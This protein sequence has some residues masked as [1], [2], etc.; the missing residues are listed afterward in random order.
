M[1][2]RCSTNKKTRYVDKPP[3]FEEVE[4]FGITV[5]KVYDCHIINTV[6]G[7]MTNGYGHINTH[8]EFLVFGDD[9]QW[10][11]LPVDMFAPLETE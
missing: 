1:K 9:K 10:M 4:Q 11:A 7:K 2:L 5:G 8:V 6:N 3:Y